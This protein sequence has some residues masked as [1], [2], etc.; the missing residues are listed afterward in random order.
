MNV[1][2]DRIQ[3]ACEALTL[4]AVSE[5]YPVLAEQAATKDASLSLIHI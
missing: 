4:S 1:Q 3:A 5:Q 2:D